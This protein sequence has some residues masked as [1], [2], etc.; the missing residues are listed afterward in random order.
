MNKSDAIDQHYLL[1]EQYRDASNFNTRLHMIQSLSTQSVDWYTWIFNLLQKPPHSRV[2]E[3]GCGPGYLWQKNL[4]RI[5]PD[6][7]ITLSD[8][9]P[10][11]LKDAHNN[12]SHSGRHFAFQLVDAQE[13]PF[14]DAHFDIVIANLMLYHVPERARAFAE[15]RRV[16]RTDGSFYAATV[17]EKAFSEVSEL[18]RAAGIPPWEDVVSFSLENGAEQLAPWFPH[19]ERHELEN[20]LLITEADPLL[21]L[22]RSGIPQSQYNE[23]KFQRLRE[24]IQQ[25]LSQH[26]ALRLN[27]NIAL[28]KASEHAQ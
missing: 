27:M 7:D 26:G 8:F 2:L 15:I 12:L 18:M 20:T 17:T 14:E 13:I 3:L 6:W 4:E 24:L 23:A 28:F 21:T 25:E 19:V 1:N 10:G 5:P 22:I 11:M 9:S 16:L